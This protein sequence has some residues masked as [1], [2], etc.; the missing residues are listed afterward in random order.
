M[1]ERTDSDCF[2][3]LIMHNLF[4]QVICPTIYITLVY[5]MT[6]Q[7]AEGARYVLFGAL[8]TCTGLVAQSMGLLIGAAATSL[9]VGSPI[10][11]ACRK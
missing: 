7:P 2:K 10:A 6:G 11:D 9:Q 5:W 3:L 1:T 8:S 4:L